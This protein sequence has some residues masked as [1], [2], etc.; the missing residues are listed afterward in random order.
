MKNMS[1]ILLWMRFLRFSLNSKKSLRVLST[2]MTTVTYNLHI[3]VCNCNIVVGWEFS[4]WFTWKPK[5]QDGMHDQIT[6]LL[7]SNIT[8]F[9]AWDWLCHFF[10]H[11][12]CRFLTL[13]QKRIW[14][15]YW[16]MC[17][18]GWIITPSRRTKKQVVNVTY[19]RLHALQEKQLH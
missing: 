3:Y 14:L 6:S 11:N 8:P 10:Y 12:C 2:R 4:Y 17:V 16:K 7:Y 13:A 9:F 15:K 19:E 5:K 18:R 1:S